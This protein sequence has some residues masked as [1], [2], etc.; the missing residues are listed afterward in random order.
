MRQWVC[1]AGL[2]LGV[3]V[4]SV[5]AAAAQPAAWSVQHHPLGQ[6]GPYVSRLQVLDLATGVVD[7]SFD[8][9]E[10]VTA[11]HG[12]LTPDG[13]YYLVPTNVGVARF[14]TMPPALDRM[15]GAGVR[16]GEIVVEPAGSRLHA[17][18]DF[19]HAVLDWETGQVLSIDCCVRPRIL[20]APD[21]RSSVYFEARGA[22]PIVET[23]VAVF[24]EPGHIEQWSVTVPGQITSQAVSGANLAV[25]SA[26]LGQTVIWNLGDGTE[27]GRLPSAVGLAWR[28]DTL[29]V[30]RPQRLSAY[31]L[32][33]LSER[34]LLEAISG[35]SA[36]G[37]LG[38]F[39]SAD[40]G[41][42]YWLR[43][44]SLLG[45]SVSGT[46]Y[47]V[48]DIETGATVAGGG[49]GPRLQTDLTLEAAPLCL[50]S[51]QALT[52]VA[53][54]G[55]NA[56]VL[57]SPGGTCRPWREPQALNP[58]P[59]T[60]P[61]TLLLP[62]GPNPAGVSRTL[63]V[64]V[65]GAD[66]RIEQAAALA[67][68]PTLTVAGDGQRLRLEWSPTS[69]GGIL[70]WVIRGAPAG[71][72]M[73]DV[74]K[75]DP[76]SRTWTSPALPPGGYDVEVV[77]ENAAGRGAAS[78][79]VRISVG[80]MDV[81][82]APEGLTATV[83]EDFVTLSWAPPSRGAVPSAYVVEATIS[84]RNGPVPVLTTSMT[85]VSLA[86]VGYPWSAVRVRARTDGG[87]SQPSGFVTVMTSPC[88][89][90]PSA[91]GSVWGVTTGG[92]ATVRW[93]AAAIGAARDYVVQVGT[94]LGASDLAEFTV[95]GSTLELTAPVPPW[96]TRA[97]VQVRARNWCGVSPPSQPV[98][99]PPV[100]G[101]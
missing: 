50:Y 75:V 56:E 30:S 1:A 83:V 20:F 48:V 37:G 49:F 54:E 95:A 72:V 6:L 16:V 9:P 8:I 76:G 66:V 39:V 29:L 24:I 4:A 31:D 60:G 67:G 93:S 19:G 3:S 7:A 96:P 59:H 65:A 43:H 100:T 44:W 32:P 11:G 35:P 85:S 90:P 64:R 61:A 17:I 86:A 14:H 22:T 71:G 74:V 38:V 94:V 68:A 15:I 89:A 63:T 53:P 82:E 21:G 36:I 98:A 55:G 84:P 57:V 13:R 45:V 42:A 101:W 41:H 10:G 99:V 18:G 92:T 28:A 80:L 88:T 70:S 40:G 33:G 12:V 2:A 87:L 69:G 47:H 34:V 97:V 78:N 91:P 58:G 52:T 46:V 27:R 77:A 79:R 26:G 5:V 25:V 23:R 62:V 81:P 51:V 73:G